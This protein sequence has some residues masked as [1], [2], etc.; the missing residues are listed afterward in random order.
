MQI[1][2]K[3]IHIIL[4]ANLDNLRVIIEQIEESGGIQIIENLQYQQN[5]H[6]SELSTVLC[7]MCYGDRD[8]GIK[9]MDLV[10]LQTNS[11]SF[12]F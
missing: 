7:N 1:I 8:D 11:T 6:I 9:E 4:C 3:I 10:S 2:L 5:S 12:N